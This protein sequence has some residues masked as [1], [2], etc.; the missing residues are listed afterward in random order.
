ML[1]SLRPAQVGL[2]LQQL[3]Y[4]VVSRQLTGG[5]ILQ[6]LQN[7]HVLLLIKQAEATQRKQMDGTNLL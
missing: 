2:P 5:N 6:K 7:Q 4:A 1:L 3:P